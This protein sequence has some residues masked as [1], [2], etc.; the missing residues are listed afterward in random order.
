MKDVKECYPFHI[1]KYYHQRE[2][3]QEPVFACLVTHVMKKIIQIPSKVKSKYWN[4]NQ[5]YGGWVPKSVKDEIALEK[6]N[7]NTLLW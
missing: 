7:G 1:S 4:W 6:L 5:K 2:I 3:S